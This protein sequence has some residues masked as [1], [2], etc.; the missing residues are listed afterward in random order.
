M[1]AASDAA[2]IAM[3]YWNIRLLLVENH[4]VTAEGL[5]RIL[6]DMPEIREIGTTTDAASALERLRGELW[7]VLLLDVALPDHGAASLVRSVR[8][9]FPRLPILAI[10]RHDYEEDAR[11]A[12]QAGASGCLPPDAGTAKGGARRA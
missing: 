9:E 5:K 2:G 10:G 7:D 11:R 12:V 1:E 4:P 8:A 6:A 3:K